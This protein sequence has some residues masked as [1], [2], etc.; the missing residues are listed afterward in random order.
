MAVTSQL[1]IICGSI[2][3]AGFRVITHN[4]TSINL[5]LFE[6]FPAVLIAFAHP[7]ALLYFLYGLGAMLNQSSFRGNEEYFL[8]ISY[9][10]YL[11]VLIPAVFINKRVVFYMLYTLLVILLI[12]NVAGCAAMPFPE[13]MGGKP[14]GN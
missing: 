8:F 10:I 6:M 4:F 11:S 9:I 13:I 12:T 3:L 14:P 5:T 7:F 1:A 2:A